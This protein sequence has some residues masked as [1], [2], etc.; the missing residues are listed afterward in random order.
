MPQSLHFLNA[1][2][3]T[4]S[5]KRSVKELVHN[6]LSL[7]ISDETAWHYEAVSIIMLTNKMSN[8]HIPAKTST[9]AMVL[10]E[11]HSHTFT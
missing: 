11:S 10:V 4:T 9:H 5:L 7:A 2:K 3:V 8:L 1:N 6:H